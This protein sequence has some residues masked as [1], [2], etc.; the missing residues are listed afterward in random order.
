MNDVDLSEA[1]TLFL[2]GYPG[3]S[4]A[5][6]DAHY[7][8]KAQDARS[9]VRAILEETM[10]VEP[11]WSSLSLNEAGDY[12]QSVMQGRHPNSSSEALTGIGNYYTYLMR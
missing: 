11:D 1:V 5:Q 10:K 2:N 9:A 4:D 8:E 12:V 3:K 6:F 7:G